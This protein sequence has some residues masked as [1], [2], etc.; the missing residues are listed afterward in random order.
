ML[1]KQNTI[2]VMPHRWDLS[3]LRLMRVKKSFQEAEAALPA[4]LLIVRLDG[5][6]H[7]PGGPLCPLSLVYRLPTRRHFY[8]HLWT[9][10]KML[11]KVA[12]HKRALFHRVVAHG[13]QTVFASRGK[14]SRPK[15]LIVPFMACFGYVRRRPLRFRRPKWNSLPR[16]TAVS[17]LG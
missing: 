6:G 5:G 1:T 16:S 12:P 8:R 13:V 9:K 14:S 11:P 7:H 10:R 2:N 15:H 17:T 4:L 3:R